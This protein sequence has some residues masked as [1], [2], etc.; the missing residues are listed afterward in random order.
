MVFVRSK[1][2]E[3]LPQTSL[4]VVADFPDDG[5]HCDRQNAVIVEIASKTRRTSGVDIPL[6]ILG[7]QPTIEADQTGSLARE[8]QDLPDAKA[9][10]NAVIA[11]YILNNYQRETAEESYASERGLA[12]IHG[13]PGTGKT[14]SMTALG[15]AHVT[16]LPGSWS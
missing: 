3:I 5:M 12:I 14:Y 9:A 1:G 8:L 16:G 6:H 2:V 4:G 15:H 11:S 10:F 13:L 7:S